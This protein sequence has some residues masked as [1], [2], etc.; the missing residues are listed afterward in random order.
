MEIRNL[1]FLDYLD[2]DAELEFYEC[3]DW[4]TS[5]YWLNKEEAILLIAHL[6]KVFSLESL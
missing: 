2:K 4:G 1:T 5:T 3:N 6:Q